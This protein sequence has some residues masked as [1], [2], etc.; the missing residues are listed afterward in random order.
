ME[1][2]AMRGV[3]NLIPRSAVIMKHAACREDNG[4]SIRIEIGNRGDTYSVSLV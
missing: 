1:I 2:W 4:K 3:I